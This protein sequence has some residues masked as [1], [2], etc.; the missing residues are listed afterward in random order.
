VG[1]STTPAC[2]TSSSMAD[3]KPS[4]TAMWMAFIPGGKGR[5]SPGALPVPT[6]GGSTDTRASAPP[7]TC[8][9][10]K[11]DTGKTM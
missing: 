11:V 2:S 7:P 5:G 4:R 6:L 8:H 1:T 3:T 9:K 10:S